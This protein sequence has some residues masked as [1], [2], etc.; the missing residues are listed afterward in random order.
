MIP[1]LLALFAFADVPVA[2]RPADFSGA[3]GGPFVVAASADKAEARVGE[4]VR[5]VLSVI[6]PG[7]LSQ[8]RRPDLTA[9]PEF[10]R[11]FVIDDGPTRD[12]TDPPGRAFE[13]SLRPKT[14][15]VEEIPRRKFVYFNP[16][17]RPASRGFQTTYTELLPLRVY[18]PEP[19]KPEVPPEVTAWADRVRRHIEEES[20][21]GLGDLVSGL[22]LEVTGMT[23]TQHGS[24]WPVA[25]LW[26]VPPAACAV[27]YWLWRRRQSA[28]ID[29]A[30][31][32]ALE[33][34][35]VADTDPAKQVSDVVC[36]FL[37]E[38]A[39]LSAGMTTPAE[40]S[41]YLYDA[42]VPLA[43]TDRVRSLLAR[44]DE[45]RYGRAGGVSP[46]VRGPVGDRGEYQGADAPCSP[47]ELLADARQLVSRWGVR[48]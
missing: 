4:P 10:A 33:R 42:G 36:E 12:L 13:Y 3:V 9:D 39:G 27:W 44:C 35:R 31:Q 40:V 38:R 1:A 11:R 43:A 28:A 18:D 20:R 32:K 5:Y 34:L 45:R 47:D 17:V 14:A 25:A 23:P 48:A 41:A 2:G 29:P 22:M 8:L 16:A 30:A 19:P 7:D 24:R 6:G 15:G 26:L 37:R 21:I 46:L